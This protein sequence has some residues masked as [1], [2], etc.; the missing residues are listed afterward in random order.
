MKDT[1]EKG[2]FEP[3]WESLGQYRCP[4][5]FRD[6]KFGIWSHWGPQ[7]VPMY[8][9]W[10][11][12][13]MYVEGHPQYLH[14]WR[15]YGH[16]SQHGWK[17]MIK[18]WKAERFDPQGLMDLYVAAGAKYFVA[19]ANHHDNFDNWNSK[20]HAW[21][22]TRVGPMKDIVGLWREAARGRGLR[23]GVTEHLGASFTWW[24]QNKHADASGPYAGVP[25]DGNDEAYVDLYHRNRGYPLQPSPAEWQWYTNNA[26]YHAQWFRR[27]QDLVDQHQPDLLYS[28]GGL[29]FY[30][31]TPELHSRRQILVNCPEPGLRLVAHLY[32]LSARL[33]GGVNEAVY[34]QKDDTSKVAA[35]G[36]LDIERGQENAI[37]PY[38]WQT[39]TC[40]G[41]WFYDVRQV[42]K[43]PPHVIEMLVD[44]VSKN[45]NLL[46]NLP[47]RP[48]GTLDDECL[49]ILRELAAWFKVNGAGIHGT[50][51][52]RVAGEGPTV[53][54]SKAWSFKE[55]AAPWTT[56]DFRF[57]A[58]GS[59]VFAF[60]MKA[61]AQAGGEAFV[62]SLGSSTGAAVTAV[63]LPGTQTPLWHRQCEDGLLV[64]YPDPM[65]SR[66][67]PCVEV[68]LAP[69][70]RT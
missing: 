54:E 67:V 56:A 30:W 22:A 15:N 36:V 19:Q 45:G 23:F 17:D 46:L 20:H 8:G 51:P 25:Y 26:D 37:K 29:P 3:T 57:T 24:E 60:Q 53:H 42:Y 48:D 63:R 16:P 1:I 55:D 47:Q 62:R 21:N 27:I 39:D 33:H 70:V 61:P 35:I 28:D 13:H 43:T 41:G 58:K 52:W 59:S 65:P 18:L 12:R 64:C 10:Y 31:Q 6:A 40:V 66:L 5:W 50:R 4:E 49:N 44:I 7:S 34:N 14:H 2:P 11:A 32:N 9:D 69:A 68:V 38:V